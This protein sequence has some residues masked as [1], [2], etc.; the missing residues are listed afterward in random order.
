MLISRKRDRTPTFK[1]SEQ[2]LQRTAKQRA[3]RNPD[4]LA[5]ECAAKVS[6]RK[7]FCFQRKKDRVPALIKTECEK[8][9]PIVLE[10]ERIKQQQNRQQKQRLEEMSV[11][12][13][14]NKNIKV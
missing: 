7:R 9:D 6:A 11:L 5:R 2:E 13:V 4:V 3:K 8:K 12:D 1:R 10:C 14:A